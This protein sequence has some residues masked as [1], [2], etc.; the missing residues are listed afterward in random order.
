MINRFTTITLTSFVALTLLAPGALAAGKRTIGKTSAQ[1]AQSTTS[2]FLGR[3]IWIPGTWTVTKTPDKTVF[4]RNDG[5]RTLTV[6]LIAIP[7]LDCAYGVIRMSSLKAWGGKSLDQSQGRIETLRLGS[8]R[9]MG[10]TWVTPSTWKGDRHICLGQDLKTA[11]EIIA[12]EGDKTLATFARNDLLLQLA[13]RQG[14]AVLP[15]RDSSSSVFVPQQSSS[16][17]GY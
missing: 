9:Y 3:S 1:S 6:S 10:Y 5:T 13:A 8:L 16:S 11:V 2:D 4:T 12:P 14:R 17:V 15:D 7:K